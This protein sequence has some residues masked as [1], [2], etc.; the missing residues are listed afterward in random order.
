[1]PTITTLL[2]GKEVMWG[3]EKIIVRI[4]QELLKFLGNYS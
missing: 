2:D 1:M 3:I 4:V